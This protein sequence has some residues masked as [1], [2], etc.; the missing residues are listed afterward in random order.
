MALPPPPPPSP[1]SRVDD[2]H[3]AY[4]SHHFHLT[5][6]AMHDDGC[7][8]AAS[9]PAPLTATARSTVARGR[10]H[11]DVTRHAAA[12][13][14]ALAPRRSPCGGGGGGQHD[15]SGGVEDTTLQRAVSA[16]PTLDD[17]AHSRAPH[18]HAGCSYD[19]ESSESTET[20]GAE[21]QLRLRAS[22]DMAAAAAAAG[23]A[24]S[25]AAPPGRSSTMMVSPHLM[26]CEA[27]QPMA[28]D[29]HDGAGPSG[30]VGSCDDGPDR[31]GAAGDALSAA[32]GGHVADT[33][34]PAHAAVVGNGG[35]G[36]RGRWLTMLHPVVA[37]M[38][39]EPRPPL[40]SMT[41][42]A[43]SAGTGRRPH[44]TTGSDAAA[45][46][47]E[48]G[49]A[50]FASLDM[51]A[52][53]GAA[54]AAATSTSRGTGGG[55]SGGD[56]GGSAL[57]PR[58]S[59]FSSSPSTASSSRLTVA[60]ASTASLSATIDAHTRRPPTA[61]AP[62]SAAALESATAS[63]AR[64]VLAAACQS[65]AADA[66][67]GDDWLL[68]GVQEVAGHLTAA[69]AASGGGGGASP[70][71]AP[72]ANDKASTARMRPHIVAARHVLGRLIAATSR[73]TVAAGS[74]ESTLSRLPVS[75]SVTQACGCG[76]SCPVRRALFRLSF[77]LAAW[78]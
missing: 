14:S 62:P 7:D 55:S 22:P 69:L 19:R 9:A 18:A 4:R 16:P 77:T 56:R 42:A 61:A 17:D 63:F 8:E 12:A 67:G 28:L 20:A 37:S 44:T 59:A 36:A 47:R 48:S 13:L 39:D 25:Q 5:P 29:G 76:A 34:A 65:A 57:A 73:P 54:G 41:T 32:G 72:P 51:D 30:V 31:L 6:L 60:S 74:D 46:A 52:L 40:R 66:D 68:C 33:A 10:Q 49:L 11:D 64:D 75:S 21:A 24:V 53:V 71:P 23:G 78:S 50:L 26:A 27:R 70:S 43:G 3:R 1:T 35:G 15:E 38:P 58:P 2:T 45:A